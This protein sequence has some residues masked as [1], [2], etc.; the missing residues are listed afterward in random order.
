MICC[1]ARKYFKALWQ[2]HF[3]LFQ[4]VKQQSQTK[5]NNYKTENFRGRRQ[6]KRQRLWQ[7]RKSTHPRQKGQ[8]LSDSHR[9]FPFRKVSPGQSSD[10]SRETINLELY[11]KLIFKCYPLIKKTNP[12]NDNN[13]L[14]QENTSAGQIGQKTQVSS[15]WATMLDPLLLEVQ[16]FLKYQRETA[17]KRGF[18]FV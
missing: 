1:E 15:F 14:A 11:V 17:M 8:L 3:Q 18:L 10:F 12:V 6:C 13:L 2:E 5:I 9:V 4:L 16:P 7:I